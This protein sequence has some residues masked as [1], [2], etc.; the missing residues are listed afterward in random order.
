[1]YGSVWLYYASLAVR[2]GCVPG[3]VIINRW[4]R[5]YCRILLQR[6]RPCCFLM[7]DI[8]H[9][10]VSNYHHLRASPGLQGAEPG[11]PLALP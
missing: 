2:R 6:S 9:H 4:H 3:S 5:T 10:C 1:M 8:M 7:V 11:G